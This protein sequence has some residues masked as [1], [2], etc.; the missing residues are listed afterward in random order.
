MCPPRSMPLIPDRHSK[1]W[2]RKALRLPQRGR[3][4][5]MES[6]DTARRRAALDLAIIGALADG[7]LRHSEAA[8]LTWGDVE[9]WADGTGQLTIQKGKN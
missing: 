2:V 3:G 6:A 1:L 5:R 9:L 8:A 7:G 4:G